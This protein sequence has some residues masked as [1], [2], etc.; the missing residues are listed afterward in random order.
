MRAS[1]DRRPFVRGLSVTLWTLRAQMAHIVA[2]LIYYLQV[3]VL[4]AGFVGLEVRT[5]SLGGT[6]N[7]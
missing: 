4:E 1:R 7:R 2:S 3:D 6:G 5:R